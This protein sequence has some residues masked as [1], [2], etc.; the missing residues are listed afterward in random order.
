MDAVNTTP[1]LAFPNG[2]DNTWG[3][4]VDGDLMKKSIR[5]YVSEGNYA[6]VPILGGLVDDEGT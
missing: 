3:I 2:M 1:S 6:G 5:Q 4:S